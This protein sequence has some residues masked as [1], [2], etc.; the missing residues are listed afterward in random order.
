L[1]ER[2]SGDVHYVELAARERQAVPAWML[3]QERCAQ[4]TYGLQPAVDVAT[5]VELADWLREQS[6]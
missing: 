4:M 6:L 2:G 1:R 3:D 5:L